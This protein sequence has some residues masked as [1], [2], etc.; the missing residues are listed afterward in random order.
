MA[1]GTFK[2]EATL[3]DAD[4]EAMH[5][6]Y[7][8]PTYQAVLDQLSP[9]DIVLEIGAG[10]LRLARQMAE[11]VQKVY[12]V[13]INSQVLEQADIWRDALPSN[14][15]AVRADARLLDFPSGI[16]T[17]VLMMRHCTS[18]RLYMDKLRNAGATR[19][20]SN[21]RWRM[22]VEVV[23]LLCSRI[24][25]SAAGMGWFACLCGGTGFKEGPAEHWSAEM[26]K[27]IYEVSSC[28]QCMEV[29]DIGK[30]MSF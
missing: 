18:F 28:P 17:G 20:I 16:T 22:Y 12:A 15:I 9:T 5:A 11:I 27:I 6:H 13:E 25:Y 2:T 14:L 4:W 30:N 26:D 29:F 8:Q 21:A 7:D 3:S 23:D 1:V 24:P 10:D 19:L